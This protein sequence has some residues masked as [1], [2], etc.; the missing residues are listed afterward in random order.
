MYLMPCQSLTRWHLCK[1]RMSNDVD[2]IGFCLYIIIVGK[3]GE[4]IKFAD[5]AIT[6][7]TAKLNFAII[8]RRIHALRNACI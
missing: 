4:D 2:V 7:Q 3:F 5:L 1:G 8:L 6:E